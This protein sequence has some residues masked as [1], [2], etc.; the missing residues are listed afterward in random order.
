MLDC[1]KSN[2]GS[3]KTIISL[4]GV[5]EREYLDEELNEMEQVYWIDVDK[6]VEEKYNLCKEFLVD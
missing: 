4:G 3:S 1:E 5:L 2:L 6:N